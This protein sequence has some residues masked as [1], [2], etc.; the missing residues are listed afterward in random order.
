MIGLTRVGEGA[1]TSEELRR[2]IASGTR[3]TAPNDVAVRDTTHGSK[4]VVRWIYRL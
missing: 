4:P 2:T 3:G 1:V